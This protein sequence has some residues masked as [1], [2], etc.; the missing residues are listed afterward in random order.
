MENQHT[1]TPTGSLTKIVT[2]GRVKGEITAPASKS[3]AQRAAAAA[4]LADGVS[5]LTHLTLCNDVSAALNVIRRL[6]ASIAHE[7]TTYSIEGGFNPTADRIDI[8]ES[9]LAARLFAPIAA[10]G[11]RPITID[12]EGSI[13]KR[14]VGMIQEPLQ[15]L[16]A[17]VT[18]RG[19]YLPLVVEGPLRGGKVTVDGSHSSQFITGLLMA[20]PLAEHDTELTVE[21]LA[22]RPYIDMTIEVLR[23]FGI[24]VTHQEYTR[25]QIK[26]GQRY[27]AAEYNIEG[28]WSGASCLLVAGAVAGAV[29]VRNLNPDSLQADKAILEALRIAG[30]K[31]T[32]T[33]NAVTVSN[34][35][36]MAFNFDAT[37][38][39][40]LFPALAVLAANSKGT[41]V[42]RGTNR[43][44]HKESNRAE[45]LAGTFR[46]LGIAVDLAEPDRM[47]ITGGKIVGAEVE[48]HNDHRIAMAAAVAALTADGPVTIRQAEAVNKS[49][50]GFWNDLE[51][52]GK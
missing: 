38:C 41:S 11:S 31:V 16:G 50:P 19:G 45:T 37:H 34:S 3:Y 10:L 20:L 17:R 48:S 2:S 52:L 6:G 9:G 35:P 5:T 29:T 51:K 46:A 26:G 23:A 15:Q 44:T 49:Y 32:T 42:I 27:A 21:R 8:G 47:K 14:P 13:L 39:P 24:E 33:R 40:D 1:N 7:G 43:L 4:L 18:S 12:G 28:D 36:L 22:S 25:F 30:A